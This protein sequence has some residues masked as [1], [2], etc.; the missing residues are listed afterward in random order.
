MKFNAVSLFTAAMLAHSFA[1]SDQGIMPVNCNQTIQGALD[2]NDFLTE[3]G[4]PFDIYMHTNLQD[5]T[6]Y[7]VVG[8]SIDFPIASIMFFATDPETVSPLQ[9]ANVFGP[10]QAMG[11][12]G[13]MA[14]GNHFFVISSIDDQA[15]VGNYSVTFL[16][17]PP[18][19]GESNENT[20]RS[21]EGVVPSPGKFTTSP[22]E[23]S[24]LKELLNA[25]INS[26]QK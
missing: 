9:G 18:E 21:L 25:A 22:H 1:W 16:C 11:L 7:G 24:N 19:T 13:I 2:S 3:T 20:F 4:R 23:N 12:L 14:S 10:G 6:L 15:P 26:L 8:G 17:A 5:G